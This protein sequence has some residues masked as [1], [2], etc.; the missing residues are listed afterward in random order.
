M[1]MEILLALSLA[2]ALPSGGVAQQPARARFVW[3]KQPAADPQTRSRGP[4]FLGRGDRDYRYTGFWVGVGL[5]ATATII[6]AAHC[7]DADNDCSVSRALLLGP[8][9]TG[10]LGLT[11]ALIG[12]LFPKAQGEPPQ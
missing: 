9:I 12:G 7:S 1:K 10:V 6:S 3:V 8:L 4:G 2:L 11:G 5:G